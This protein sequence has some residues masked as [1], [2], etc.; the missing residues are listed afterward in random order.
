MITCIRCGWLADTRGHLP[1]DV[2]EVLYVCGPLCP[3]CVDELVAWFRQAVPAPQW[4][5][6]RRTA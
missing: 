6:T 5:D 3:S 2:A 1:T 4:V